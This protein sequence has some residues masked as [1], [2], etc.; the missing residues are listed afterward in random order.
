MRTSQPRK[1]PSQALIQAYQEIA[2]F[3]RKLC[4]KHCITV[5][6]HI[7]SCC[8]KM[9]CEIALERAAQYG[10]KLEHVSANPCFLLNE[11]GCTVDPWL[12]S[13]CAVH[14]CDKCI[15]FNIRDYNKYFKLRGKVDKL[16]WEETKDEH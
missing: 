15:Y 2:D 9:Y 7:G 14:V 3:T 10:I 13:M 6:E 1:L 12:R 11:H 4:E 8:D 5:D 16:E